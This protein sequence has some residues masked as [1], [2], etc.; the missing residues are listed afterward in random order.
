MAQAE[1]L[2]ARSVRFHNDREVRR[3]LYEPSNHQCLSGSRRLLS[4][5]TCAGVEQLHSPAKRTQRDLLNRQISQRETL[6][7]D[8]IN[9]ASRIYAKSVTHGIEN[10]D[11]LVSL[12]ALVSRIRLMA[13]EPVFLYQLR[14][15]FVKRIVEHYGEPNL[16]VEQLRSAAHV[17]KGG[18][19]RCLQHG[20][21]ER[22]PKRSATRRVVCNLTGLRVR[23][24]SSSTILT[25]R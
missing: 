13:T 21:P 9:E 3:P 14:K 7:S 15:V 24:E 11:E 8:F 20:L 6:Y 4:W 2:N 23:L 25:V 5:R 16:T 10:M 18:A 17:C 22:D 19:T 12:Y 1:L